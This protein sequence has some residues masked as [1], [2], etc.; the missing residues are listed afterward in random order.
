VGTQLPAALGADG[1]LTH[2]SPFGGSNLG[3]IPVFIFQRTGNVHLA[4]SA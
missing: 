3:G 2:R 4:A 1:F